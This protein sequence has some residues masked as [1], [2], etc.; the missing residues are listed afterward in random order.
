MRNAHDAMPVNVLITQKLKPKTT[1]LRRYLARAY[2][3]KKDEVEKKNFM[4][5][6]QRHNRLPIE[7]KSHS[8]S[9]MLQHNS[10]PIRIKALE[11]D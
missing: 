3:L 2:P 1:R 11:K 6:T 8:R 7:K 4:G 9:L 10:M 5:C